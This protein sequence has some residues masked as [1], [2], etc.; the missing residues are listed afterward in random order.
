MKG[1]GFVVV[2]GCLAGVGASGCGSEAP[3]PSYQVG[4]GLALDGE[5]LRVVYGDGPGTAVQGNDTRLLAASTA[6]QAGTVPQNA[7]LA[8]A[9]TGQVVGPLTANTEILLDAS[10]QAVNSPVPLLRVRNTSSEASWDKY[11][12]L[13]VD[14]VGGLVARGELG[15]GQMPATGRGHRFMWA[16]HKAAFRAGYAETQWD[17]ANVGFFSFASGNLTLA[18]AHG[19]FAHGDQCAATG[20]TSVCFGSLNKA[21]GTASL[22]TGASSTASGFASTALGYTNVASGQG[23]VALGY[24]TT[25][26]AD[27]A[28][29]LGQRVGSGGFAGSFIWGDQSSTTVSTNSAANQFMVRA[30]GGLR[31]RTSA[32]LATG[33]DLPAGSGVFSCTSDR[34]TK[35]DFRRVNGEDVLAKV[36]QMPVH[37]WRYKAEAEGVRHVG[38]VAQDFRAAF[39]LGTDDKSIGLLDIDGVNMVAIQALA[40]RT[41]ELDAKSAEV[42]ALKAELA[43]LK[44]GLVRLEAAVQARAPRR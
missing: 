5:A 13:A 25:A 37:S 1:R 3:A 41:Q 6:L 24:R 40:R 33:C 2:W 22:A 34:D 36:L 19:S 17:E 32:T 18:S 7:S 42:D 14:S 30:A 10:A 43:E 35:E 16:P 15:I 9:G 28:T 23:S 27:Y 11:P 31:L 38:P 29:A 4:M 26:D 20:V 44:R 21:S 39:G 12:L 8:V